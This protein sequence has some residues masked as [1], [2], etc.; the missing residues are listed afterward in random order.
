ML[1]GKRLRNIWPGAAGTRSR[2]GTPLSLQASLLPRDRPRRV[3]HPESEA[4]AL[5]AAHG[6]NSEFV[7]DEQIRNQG[8]T[9]V[10]VMTVD[11]SIDLVHA[12]YQRAIG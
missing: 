4:D 10:F 5:H 8:K 7:I 6:P 1:C 9:M 3:A 11:M 12:R 2:E